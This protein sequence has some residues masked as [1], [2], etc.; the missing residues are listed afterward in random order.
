MGQEKP[1]DLDWLAFCYIA[2]ELSPDEAA[3]F[4]ERLADD[5]Q[6]REAV[7][8]AVELTR[9]VAAACPE[10]RS[11]PAPVSRAARGRRRAGPAGHLAWTAIAVAACLVVALLAYQHQHRRGV[12]P[13]AEAPHDGPGGEGIETLGGRA[14]QLAVLWSRTR[15]ELAALPLD[16]WAADSLEE[17]EPSDELPLL[18]ADEDA[19][20]EVDENGLAANTPPSWMLAAVRA[21]SGSSEAEDFGTSGPEEN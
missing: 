8:R 7:A 20:E 18:P 21:V 13:V 12:A 9:A 14:D 4:E 5:Q 15:D 17:G 19:D 6:A 10:V 3:A 16:D 1:E 2:D 11:R